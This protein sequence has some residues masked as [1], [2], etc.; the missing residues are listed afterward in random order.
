MF[1]SLYLPV[2]QPGSY[3]LRFHYH[4]FGFHV[5]QLAV[6]ME[7]NNNQTLHWQQNGDHGNQWLEGEVDLQVPFGSQVGIKFM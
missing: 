1:F 4:M 7:A 6:V 3:C 5:N 2:L